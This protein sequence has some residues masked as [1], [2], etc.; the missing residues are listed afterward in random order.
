MVRREASCAEC[1]QELFPG[2]LLRK[3]GE[4]A[5]CLACA[6]LDH[7]EYLPAGNAAIT[8]RAGQYSRLKAVVL[9]WSRTRKQYER[10]GILAESEAIDRA[11]QESADDAEARARRQARAAERR[12]AED[13]RYVEAFARAVSQHFPGCPEQEAREIARHA[14]RKHSGRIGRTAAARA[15]DPDAV[16]LAVVA[17][18]RHMHTKYDELLCRYDDRES[19]RQEVRDQVAAV[20]RRWEQARS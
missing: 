5:L 18:V 6:D 4:K 19:A 13:E 12:A 7:L 20:L 1:G 9:R 17:H 14:C 16:R 15:F 2:S 3:E 10:Q 8:R 11:E